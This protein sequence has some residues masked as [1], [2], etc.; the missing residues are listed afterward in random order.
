MTQG[1]D[2][3]ATAGRLRFEEALWDELRRRGNDLESPAWHRR[4]LAE[5][6]RRLRAGQEAV[7]DWGVAKASIRRSV[8]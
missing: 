2:T 7:H 8:R 4:V 6:T 1:S 5:R 3:T